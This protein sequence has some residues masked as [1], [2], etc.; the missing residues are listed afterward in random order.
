[1]DR[2]LNVRVTGGSAIPALLLVTGRGLNLHAVRECVVG[3]QAA[4]LKVGADYA[5][6]RILTRYQPS[7][8]LNKV[9]I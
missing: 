9:A 6:S 2:I 3:G 8:S 1:L 5:F 7:Q 4:L